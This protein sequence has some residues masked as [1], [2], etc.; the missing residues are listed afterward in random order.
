VTHTSSLAIKSTRSMEPSANRVPFHCRTNRRHS[1]RR[2][3]CAYDWSAAL[4]EHTQCNTVS[5]CPF[6]L[7]GFPPRSD[8]NILQTVYW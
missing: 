7:F 3:F 5:L 2:S 6:F 8:K 1:S 4:P